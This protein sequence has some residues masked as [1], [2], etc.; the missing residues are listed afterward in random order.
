MPSSSTI[1]MTDDAG[2]RRLG[3]IRALSRLMAWL[4]LFTAA[5]L[6]VGILAYWWTTPSDLLRAQAGLTGPGLE[7]GA[8]TRVAGFAISMIPVGILIF[9][10]VYARQCFLAF[11]DGE[12]FSRRAV[13]R[14]RAFAIAVAASA[15]LKPVAGAALSVL[16]SWNGEGGSVALRLGSD[17]LLTLIFAGLVAV[18]AWVMAEAV[19]ISEE[20]AQFV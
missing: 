18:I 3:R 4:V 19:A 7:I 2:Q 13:G 5:A 12:I 8:A 1:K 9:G 16:L 20:N 11:A 6:V 10:L 15:A 17:T 14:L